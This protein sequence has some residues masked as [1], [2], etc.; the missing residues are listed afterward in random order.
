MVLRKFE[1]CANG[2]SVN[3][4]LALPLGASFKMALRLPNRTRTT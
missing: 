2:Q 4:E 3:R 1:G